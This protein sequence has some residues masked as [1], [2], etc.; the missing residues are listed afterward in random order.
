[1]AKVGQ[2]TRMRYSKKMSI[3]YSE[4]ILYPAHPNILFQLERSLNGVSISM[5]FRPS[6]ESSRVVVDEC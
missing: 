5:T 6:Q 4:W 3:Y 2:A 1:M